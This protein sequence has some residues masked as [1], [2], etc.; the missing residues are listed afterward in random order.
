MELK[1]ACLEK[2]RKGTENTWLGTGI[3]QVKKNG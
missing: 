1:S 3:R 2:L